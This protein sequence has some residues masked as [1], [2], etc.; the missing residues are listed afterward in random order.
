MFFSKYAKAVVA[1]IGGVAEVIN[2]V[3]LDTVYGL[4]EGVT[5][6][7]TVVI[8]ILTAAGVYLKRNKKDLVR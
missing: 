6:G 3:I 7:L 4:D 2:R 8:A 1:T 5:N